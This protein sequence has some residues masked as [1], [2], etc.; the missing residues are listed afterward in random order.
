M[1]MTAQLLF[2]ATISVVPSCSECRAT[3]LRLASQAIDQAGM[4]QFVIRAGRHHNH[5]V[6]PA[7]PAAVLFPEPASD[8][9]GY[10]VSESEY[11]Q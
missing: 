10:D 9:N 7:P 6:T 11:E 2:S 1:S 4:Q 8:V 5:E 3:A